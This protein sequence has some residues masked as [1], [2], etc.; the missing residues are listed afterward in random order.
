MT[1]KPAA[2]IELR[3]AKVA[4]VRFPERVIDLIA[5]P[6]NEW[7]TVAYRDRLIEEQ[8]APGAFGHVQDRAKKF[9]V[10]LEHDLARVVGRVLRLDPDRP[11]GL[12]SEVFIRRGD[13]FDQVLDDAADG[14][15][16][17]SVGFAVHPENQEWS[18]PDRGRRRIVKA[19]LDHIALTYTPA[20]TGANVVAVRHTNHPSTTAAAGLATPNLDR[21][22]AERTA[23][24][25]GVSL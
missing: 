14:M 8:F 9:L 25:Y 13:E 24:S 15:Y 4:D 22:L 16:D 20:Y 12:R 2:P 19:Y 23:A 21:V 11:E 10:N 17:G 5:V 18:G 1:S 7:T 3:T 6:Y